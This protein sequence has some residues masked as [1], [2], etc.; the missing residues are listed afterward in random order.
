[1]RVAHLERVFGDNAMGEPDVAALFKKQCSDLSKALLTHLE[2]ELP[3]HVSSAL[4][5]DSSLVFR[6]GVN[7]LKNEG[8]FEKFFCAVRC[9]ISAR[10]RKHQKQYRQRLD[11]EFPMLVVLV[12]LNNLSLA[13]AAERL[14]CAIVL[15]ESEFSSPTRKELLQVMS[16]EELLHET[17]ADERFRLK[18]ALGALERAKIQVET[19]QL[20]N[21]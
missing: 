6:G 12:T 15:Q 14:S 19:L 1:M 3:D 21:K 13:R 16:F 4:F 11:K 5:K 17:C 18:K 2:E 9:A 20:K 10:L 8:R 7:V